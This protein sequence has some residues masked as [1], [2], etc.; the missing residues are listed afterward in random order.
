QD[1]RHRLQVSANSNLWWGFRLSA[2]VRM[3]SA[4]PY[5]ITS[6][7]DG[8]GDGVNNERPANTTRN[9]VRGTGSHNLDG[10]LTW[11]T[12]LGERALPPARGRA[13]SPPPRPSPLVRIEFY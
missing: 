11:G 1:I 8:N 4:A 9:S 10:T 13:A 6:G 5:T 12:G 2:N 7:L 3:Q